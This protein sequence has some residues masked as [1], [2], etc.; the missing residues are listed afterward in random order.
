M[1]IVIYI[2]YMPV[3]VSLSRFLGNSLHQSHKATLRCLESGSVSLSLCLSFLP[4][5]FS[6]PSSYSASGTNSGISL[7]FLL[8]CGS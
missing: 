5:F 2:G 3:E 6:D 1:Y 7:L 8:S 4:F